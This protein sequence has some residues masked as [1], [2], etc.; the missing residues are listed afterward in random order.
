MARRPRR[1]GADPR[2]TILRTAAEEFAAK[3]FAASRVEVLARKAKVNK[4]LIY[5]YFDSK[6][7]LYR[8]VVRLGVAQFAARMHPIVE[9][10]APA[11][12]K[13]RHWIN[14]L[15][16]HFTEQPTLPR[17]MLR[18]LADG[19]A[20][21]DNDTLRDLTTILPLVHRMVRQGQEE[22]TFDPVD[23]I[24][25]HFVLMGSLLLFT[26]NA[27]IRRRIR[28]LGFAQPPLDLQPFVRHLQQFAIRSLRKD[29]D[30][31][32]SLR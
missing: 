30:H 7:G 21:L 15:A 11:E 17:I 8:Q 13:L 2:E 28:Q 16:A 19:G 23:P 3:G 14:A 22:G 1:S 10:P 32:H 6:L 25:L 24:A 4:A 26:T 20:H 27:P 18:E 29:P 9:G 12:A 31:V 5:Y